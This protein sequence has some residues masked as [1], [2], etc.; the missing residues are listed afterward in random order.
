VALTGAA[1]PSR[2]RQW[3]ARPCL[4]RS[5]SG[6][7]DDGEHSHAENDSGDPD[8]F[9]VESPSWLNDMRHGGN[10]AAAALIWIMCAATRRTTVNAS[11]R[12]VAA[13]DTSRQFAIAYCPAQTRRSDRRG[14]ADAAK[15]VAGR[16][17]GR[18]SRTS[19]TA[20]TPGRAI[21]SLATRTCVLSAIHSP[22]IPRP[23]ATSPAVS[24]VRRERR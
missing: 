24:A 7:Q 18:T 19:A 17:R 3:S 2:R 23:T 13:T 11:A 20:R 21:G 5:P 4:P 22:S 15:T 12:S 8:H 10:R 6:K 14:S 16:H 9:D 1:R